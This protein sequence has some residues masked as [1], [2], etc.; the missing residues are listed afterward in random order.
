MY[1]F[2][3]F[4]Y[5]GYPSSAGQVLSTKTYPCTLEISDS[6]ISIDYYKDN[7]K[8][9]FL[10]NCTIP[11]NEVQMQK[12]TD[13]ALLTTVKMLYIQTNS[14]IITL[15]TLQGTTSVDIDEIERAIYAAR[16]TSVPVQAQPQYSTPTYPQMATQVYPQNP[17]VYHQPVQYQPVSTPV[18]PQSPTPPQPQYAP[19]KPNAVAS[20]TEEIK[21]YKELLDMG[22]ITQEDY[23][24]KK[25]ELLGF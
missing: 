20:P 2:E 22:A 13:K 18:Y 6:A 21:K 5:D 8:K 19:P 3:S 16:D 9:R 4:F 11:L 25:N 10:G 24:R 23:D 12:K 1:T 17:P 14:K 15:A 7:K